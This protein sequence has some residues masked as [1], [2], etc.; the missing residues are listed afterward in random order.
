[1]NSEP[2]N[3]LRLLGIEIATLIV[4]IVIAF[5]ALPYL[6]RLSWPR[7]LFVKTWRPSLLVIVLA[8]VGRALFLP[9][10]GIPEPHINDEFSY[11]LMSDTFAHHRL[12]NVTPQ[13]WQ[14]F[15]TFHVTLTPSYHSKYPIGQGVFLALG[16]VIFHQPWVG[17]WLS[18]ALLCGAICWA[19]QAFVPPPWAF[20]GG[21]LA[22]FR[23]ALFSYWV[24]SYWGGSIPGLGGAL[25]LGGVVRIFAANR[26]P[27]YRQGS[28]QAFAAGLWILANSRPYEGLAFSV[29]LLIYFL[30]KLSSSYKR[31]RNILVPAL[32]PVLLVAAVGGSFMGY[33][34][35]RTTGNPF[36]MPRL[37][38]EKTYAPLP[39]LIGQP[40]QT[41]FVFSDPAF[42]KYYEVEAQEHHLMER[43]TLEGL[44]HLEAE[45]WARTWFFYVGIALSIPVLLGFIECLKNLR[46]RIV[47][48]CA[49]TTF[50]AVSACNWTQMHYYAPAT[51]AVY[52][53]MA[54]G[55]RFLW[56]NEGRGGQAF[57]VAVVMTVIVTSLARLNGSTAPERTHFPD[58]RKAVAERL[59][60]E[61][62]RQL[63]LVTYDLAKHYPGDELVHNSADFDS[64]K[65]LW[66]R[67]KGAERDRD[68]CRAY[69]DRAFWSLM[70][71]DASYSIKPIEL[72]GSPKEMSGQPTAAPR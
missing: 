10:A 40:K 50:L 13:Q 7:W 58:T 70:T 67:S 49:I 22:V 4:A 44:I 8:L 31:E 68:L 54:E 2:I 37:Q 55:L 56:D 38:N 34:N 23:F 59:K 63:I 71:D 36:L 51:V 45:R 12:A 62:G 42:E 66:A 11:L 47:V 35:H 48:F 3:G 18:T 21:L 30:Y 20:I 57:A 69:S 25:A 65:V 26:T 52:L 64:Q 27:R 53:F 19:L 16:Q 33:Y 41:H 29:P 24:N 9:V 72:C 32:L 17:V 5:V 6:R 46:L 39:F 43:V 28:A 61:P 1:M 14:F 60:D 15:E